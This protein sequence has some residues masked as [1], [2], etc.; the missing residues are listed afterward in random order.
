MALNAQRFSAMGDRLSAGATLASCGMPI[1]T[2]PT[3]RSDLIAPGFQ[4]DLAPRVEALLAYFCYSFACSVMLSW[5][6]FV[7]DGRQRGRCDVRYAPGG[8]G[9]RRRKLDCQ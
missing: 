5:F 6:A 3:L 7:A 1:P 2:K 9:L 4:D 8:R